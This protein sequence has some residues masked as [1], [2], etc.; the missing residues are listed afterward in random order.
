M[1]A[2]LLRRLLLIPPTLI[3]LSLLVFGLAA[4]APGD[5]A[6]QYARRTHTAGE[7][8]PADIAQARHQLGLDR[9]FSVRYVEWV[10]AAVRG[11]LGR[12]F[13]RRT[14]VTS[15]IAS[16]LGATAGLAV[17]ALLLATV[18]AIPLG[19]AAAMLREHWLDHI[20]RVG[21]LTGA[22]IPGFFLAYLLIGV[23]AIRLHAL[24][25]AGRED[26]SSLLLPA[27]T[28]AV[29]PAAVISR[30][31]RSS[32]LEVL[33]EDY[34]RT[35]R[36]KGLSWLRA[37]LRHA[38]PNAAIP[39]VTVLGGVLGHLLAGAVI[40]EFIFAWPGLGR[41]TV[42]AVFERDYPMIEG[43]VVFTGLLFLLIN[44]LVDL[45]YTL[46]DPRIRLEA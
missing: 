33:G 34:V 26:P 35:A 28:L 17:V 31:L 29:G 41:L 6:E 13:A 22:S 32:L 25:V 15:E 9:P 45:S 23:F 20:L 16:R 8:T 24:P 10:R 39:V 4:L 43:L 2:Y 19:V 14:P 3:G 44:L 18:I 12:S 1:R 38:L 27:L 11:D 7:V 40:V 46:F 21:S 42:E 5:P 36:A 37:V 30:L